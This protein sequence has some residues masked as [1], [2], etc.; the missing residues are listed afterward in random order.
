MSMRTRTVLGVPAALA[1]A[2]TLGVFGLTGCGQAPQTAEQPAAEQ[3][4]STE[5]AEPQADATDPT[6][7]TEASDYVYPPITGATSDAS[8]DNAH[9]APTEQLI[10]L[11]EHDAELKALLE[12]SIAQAAEINPDRTTNPA[13]TLDEY[14]DYLDW[15]AT[16]LPQHLARRLFWNISL[17]SQ[18]MAARISRAG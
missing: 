3:A 14:Y 7:A 18:P 16:A 9:A 1:L 15:A 8:F 11:V 12:K 13:Q 4:E 17:I 2:C 5:A 10:S 6:D